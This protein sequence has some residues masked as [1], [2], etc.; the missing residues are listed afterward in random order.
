[1]AAAAVD[2]NIFR[3]RRPSCGEAVTGGMQNLRRSKVFSVVFIAR[4][5]SQ[6]RH[7]K[8]ESPIA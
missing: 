7:G 8:I 2:Q 4:S 3:P 5:G 6:D 1:M